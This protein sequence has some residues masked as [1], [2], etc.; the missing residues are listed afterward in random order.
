[1]Q[2]C[3]SLY[4]YPERDK[5]IQWKHKWW[6]SAR[7]QTKISPSTTPTHTHANFLLLFYVPYSLW[8]N[9]KLRREILHELYS[10]KQIECLA[11]PFRK[12]PYWYQFVNLNETVV[13][14]SY[15]IL[16][17]R[18]NSNLFNGKVINLPYY[19]KDIENVQTF[20]N[21]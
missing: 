1:M 17:I 20:H 9:R 12:C 14:I 21:V 15:V 7:V 3:C 4:K 2:L 13:W 8:C 11:K 18:F 10:W 5:W 6:V 16:N 19:K